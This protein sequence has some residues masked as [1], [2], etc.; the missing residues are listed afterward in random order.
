MSAWER[1]LGA[2]TPAA[3]LPEIARRIANGV[4]RDVL[5]QLNA[6]DDLTPAIRARVLVKIA[7]HIYNNAI[8]TVTAG[9]LDLQIEAGHVQ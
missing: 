2:D 5:G 7:P 9:W 4:I 8:D 1:V 6:N 3:A